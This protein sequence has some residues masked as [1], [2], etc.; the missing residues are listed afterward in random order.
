MLGKSIAVNFSSDWKCLRNYISKGRVGRNITSWRN[1]F[2]T[3]LMRIRRQSYL[4]TESWA[5]KDELT[6]RPSVYLTQL[7]T[8]LSRSILFHVHWPISSFI[9]NIN[10]TS[11]MLKFTLF[12][13]TTFSR[14]IEISQYS[15]LDVLDTIPTSNT[16]I[17]KLSSHG[18]WCSI[19][20]YGKIGTG[21]NPVD[22]LD[23]LCRDY[24]E[25]KKCLKNEVCQFQSD[26]GV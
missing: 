25:T 6:T 3:S 18:C 17:S 1:S 22:E 9:R 24:F 7:D 26:Y 14:K 21:G 5:L 11:N 10:S 19:L 8:L 20:G 12:L 2:R 23:H 15:I 13:T 4:P 16:D